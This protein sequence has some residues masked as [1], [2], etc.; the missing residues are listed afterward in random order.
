[1]IFKKFDVLLS[2]FGINIEKRVLVSSLRLLLEVLSALNLIKKKLKMSNKKSN[3]LYKLC[4]FNFIQDTNFKISFNK[5]VCFSFRGEYFKIENTIYSITNAIH[6]DVPLEKKPIL[7]LNA[8]IIKDQIEFKINPEY[9]EMAKKNLIRELNLKNRT[10]SGT[11]QREYIAETTEKLKKI[12]H[13]LEIT[14]TKGRGFGK[15]MV[16]KQEGVSTLTHNSNYKYLMQRLKLLSEELSNNQTELNRVLLIDF[17]EKNVNKNNLYFIFFFDF[18]GR[19]Y[20]TS[21]YSPISNKIIRSILTY[22]NKFCSIVEFYIKNKN[23]YTLQN[24][25]WN[26]FHVLDRFKLTNSSDLFKSGLI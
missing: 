26:Y 7:N 6:D 17:L 15:P 18:R 2:L 19:M 4:N 12:H 3:I 25:K 5:P 9:L 20:S 1:M 23:S 10:F 8:I 16:A 13:S 14:K 24:I 22:S 21:V 11:Y